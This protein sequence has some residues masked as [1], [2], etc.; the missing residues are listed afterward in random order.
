MFV[1][2]SNSIDPFTTHRLHR[3]LF[4]NGIDSFQ[5]QVNLY[6]GTQ[7]SKIF[8]RPIQI[9]NGIGRKLEFFEERDL[10][11]PSILQEI[12][13]D[14]RNFEYNIDLSHLK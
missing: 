8:Y 6:R 10:G 4:W 9:L 2:V 3:L 1:C 12:L 14:D 5:T 7:G 11:N 13:P